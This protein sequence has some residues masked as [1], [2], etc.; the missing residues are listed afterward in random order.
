MSKINIRVN[1]ASFEQI[2]WKYYNTIL[3]KAMEQEFSW[4]GLSLSLSIAFFIV[5]ISAQTLSWTY[6]SFAKAEDSRHFL[7]MRVYQME[8]NEIKNAASDIYSVRTA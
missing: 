8:R 6:Q 7:N 2:G 4:A 1:G 3:K 5:I